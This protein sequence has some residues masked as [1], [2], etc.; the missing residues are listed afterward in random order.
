M[1]FSTPDIKNALSIEKYQNN[2]DVSIF[3]AFPHGSLIQFVLK[4]TRRTGIS[5][6]FLHL[7]NDDS[8]EFQ[9]LPLQFQ[10]S[11]LGYDFYT[12]E[13]DLKKL[14]K[15]EP[16]GLFYYRF[17]LFADS[18]TKFFTHSINNFDFELKTEPNDIGFFRLLVYRQDYSV[19]SW[20]RTC[21]MYH[22]FVD[23][24]YKGTTAVPGRTDAV[25][26]SD[27]ENGIPEFGA[28]IGA[29]IPNNTF[30]GGTLYGICEKLDYLESLGVNCL[31]LSPIFRAFS[32]HKYDTGDYMEIDE[33]FGGKDAFDKLL[34]ECKRRGIFIILDGVFNH[35][36][37]DSRYFNAYGK[38]DSIGAFQSESSPY[39]PWYTFDR[40]PDEYKCW[41][42]IKILPK[43][44][45]E[46][47]SCRDF[48]LG[49]GGVIKQ[50]LQ[51]GISGFRLDV[52]D[53]LPECFLDGLRKSAKDENPHALI[54]GEVWENAA[55]KIAYG[56]RRKY[57]QGTELDS[58]MNYP[59]KNAIIEF[60]KTGLS[61][62]LYHAV[63][64][65][66]ASY[67][68]QVSDSLMN[69][70]GTHD[71]KRILTELAGDEEGDKSIAAL[72]KLRMSKKQRKIGIYRLKTAA[73]LQFTLPG[74]PSIYY[75]DEAG[76]EGYCDPFCRMPFPWGKEDLSLTEHYKKLCEIKRNEAALADGIL[77]ICSHTEGFFHFER[78]S[79][80]RKIAVL[81]NCSEKEKFVS[82]DGAGT[83]LLDGKTVNSGIM[84]PSCTA[85]ILKF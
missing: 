66:Y 52:A 69:L 35:T 53:E 36:G 46:T 56:K 55:D 70:L 29:D 74:V 81:A 13:L 57:L 40:F 42:N 25:I 64:E 6:I 85:V 9:T 72:S 7:R 5:D 19:P 17:E 76:M 84:I 31:Y 82:I 43:L 37:N 4:I 11:A 28:Y 38:Y 47:P 79:G 44:N 32:N 80:N 34:S 39:F 75:G 83:S 26:N 73:V 54:I 45:T 78:V 41:W 27:W 8:G 63:T 10:N 50:Y 68:K 60:V 3:G 18:T 16:S 21:V 61:D 22:I 58:V 23:R 12:I 33:M 65:I 62:S 59:Y 67:P 71:T 2:Q 48:F 30:F 15:E 24:F 51:K 20:F 77:H 14:C 49:E 1:F